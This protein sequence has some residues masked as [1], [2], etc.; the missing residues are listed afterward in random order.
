[1]IFMPKKKIIH[2][3]NT[4]ERGGAEMSL[5]RMLPLL[6][7]DIESIFITLKQRGSLADQFQDNAIRVISL[8]QK[9]YF[10]F[11]SMK[12]LRKILKELSPDLIVT[13]LLYP[14][15]VGRFFIQNFSQCKVVSSIAT[16]YNSP[17][18]FIARLFERL[19][20]PLCSGYMANA[21]AVKQAYIEKFKVPGNKIIVV[22]TGMDIDFFKALQPKDSLRKELAIHPK[23]IVII[24]V[25]NLHPNKGH[26]YLL[27][28]FEQAYKTNAHIKLLIVGD[29]IEKE[30]LK[31]QTGEYSS[32]NSIF[33]LGQRPDV[34][35]LLAI[36]DIFALATF[37]EGMCNAIME[38]M[39]RGIPVITTNIVENRELVT[40]GKTGLLCP[41][42]DSNGFT[43]A[44]TKLINDS[45]LRLTLGKNAANEME[46]KYNLQVTANRWKNFLLIQSEK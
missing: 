36:S 33:F 5:L 35:D 29:G 25:A 13:H 17:R 3:I 21:H 38:A 41:L 20:H 42:Q 40:E 16:T 19:T 1:M 9:G 2:I 10:D 11:S 6:N 14:D 28:A 31:R 7:D 39:S 45:E 32:K 44:L 18:Y 27:E 4:L 34:P 37:F 8:N 24:C 12:E 15:I 26:R 23:D 30:N 43:L 22:Q 46:E